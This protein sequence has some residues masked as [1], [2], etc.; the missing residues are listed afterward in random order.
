MLDRAGLP[1]HQAVG[2]DDLGTVNFPDALMPET[3]PQD[4]YLT[5]EVPDRVNADAALARG[6][7]AA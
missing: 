2:P 4:R 3:N 7:R 6:A 5:G 1:V